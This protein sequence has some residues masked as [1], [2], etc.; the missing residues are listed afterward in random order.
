M[1]RFGAPPTV[2]GSRQR[3][4]ALISVLL[5]TAILIGLTTQILS[6][7]HLVIQQNQ[8]T[9]EQS[10]A[11]QYV[12]GAEE[13]TRQVLYDDAV[14]SGPGVDHLDEFWAQPVLP[15]DLDGIGVMQAYVLDLNRCFNLNWLADDEDKAQY[16]RLQRLLTHLQLSPELA[17]LIKDWVDSDQQVSGLGAE[18]S[19]YQ[20]Q[21]PPHFA[22]NQP[23]LDLSELNMLIDVDPLEVE[24]LSGEVCLVPDSQSK[25]NVN[26]AAAETLYALDNAISIQDAQAIAQAA[27]NYQNVAEFVQN[28]PEFAAVQ[29]RLSVTSEYFMLVAE[30]RLNRS[31]VSLT[32]VL[33]RD[34]SNG[35]IK[36]LHRDFG[37]RF[38]VKTKPETSQTG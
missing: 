25:I 8:N 2:P 7:Q 24:V 22:A 17:D 27:R 36:L 1:A 34:A 29:Q 15:L 5:I 31:R 3:G 14:N 33:Y 12:L 13:L 30:A 11:V 4:I 16:K 26:T 23:M 32:S 37:K 35:R 19:A 21:T 10:Q 18:D 20:M 38:D 6:R 9:F 28:H